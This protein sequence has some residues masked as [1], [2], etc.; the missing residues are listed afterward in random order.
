MSGPK[1]LWA[2]R[3]TQVRSI[4]CANAGAAITTNIAAISAATAR[5]TMIRLNALPATISCCCP[6]V[7]LLECRERGRDSPALLFAL[8]KDCGTNR[9]KAPSP[10]VLSLAGTFAYLVPLS[11]RSCKSS[12]LRMSGPHPL[13]CAWLSLTP[14]YQAGVNNPFAHRPPGLRRLRIRLCICGVNS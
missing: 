3:C 11:R 13:P 5:T 10:K 7:F 6:I 12:V 2:K 4:P 1:P 14:P 9:E 8:H